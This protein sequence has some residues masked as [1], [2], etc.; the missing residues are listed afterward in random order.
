MQLCYQLWDS[1][2]TTR[3]STTANEACSLTHR[4]CVRSDFR[5]VSV[6]RAAISSR[7]RRA[8]AGLGRQV[9]R[10]PVA[11][12]PPSTPNRSSASSRPEEHAGHPPRHPLRR[13]PAR[14]DP[15]RSSSST[16]CRPS[17]IVIAAGPGHYADFVERVQ[18]TVPRNSSGHTGLTFDARPDD[19]WSMPTCKHSRLFDAILDAKETRS[20]DGA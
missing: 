9:R 13:S 18:M 7:R 19:T 1:W 8:A 5:R 11:S 6:R 12:S 16:V 15:N 3:S 2:M 20:G 14:G 10:S 4:K 17:S